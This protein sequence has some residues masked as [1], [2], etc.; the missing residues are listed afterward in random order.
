MSS[1]EQKFG[2]RSRHEKTIKSIK[3]EPGIGCKL[4]ND[5]NY[6]IENKRLT[7]V[8]DPEE[9]KDVITKGYFIEKKIF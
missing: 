8:A 6:D 9:Q 2:I 3:G 4:T 7:N 5:S 1:Y